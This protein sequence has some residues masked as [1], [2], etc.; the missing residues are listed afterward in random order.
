MNSEAAH[1]EREPNAVANDSP[2]PLRRR[3]YIAFNER[4]YR[5]GSS[6]HNS[7][8]P[9]AVVNRMRELHEE[10]NFGYR[11]LA[12][13][14][15]VSRGTVQKICTYRRRAQTVARWQRRT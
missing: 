7:T 2:G 6:H 14:F 4:G 10:F 5:V 3:E 12:R 9:D 13:M 1:A 15:G 11:V 8:I